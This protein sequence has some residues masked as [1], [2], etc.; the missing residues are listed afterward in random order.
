MAA[1]MKISVSG[2]LTGLGDIMKFLPKKYTLEQ[3]LTLKLFTRQIQAVADTAEALEVGDITNID[4]II[5]KCIT[6][7]CEVD[8]SWVSSFSTEITILEGETQIFKPS[9]TVYI[10]NTVAEAAVSTVEYMVVGR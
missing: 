9:G 8:T 10:R 7:D 2:E 6:K 1:A 4:M 3:T 5:M